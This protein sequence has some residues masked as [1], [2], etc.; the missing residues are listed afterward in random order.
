MR[1]CASEPDVEEAP[2]LVDVAAP[3]R[4]LAVLQPRHEDGIPLEPLCP[5]QRQQ[6]DARR[7]AR[8]ETALELGRQ[9]GHVVQVPCDLD[10]A[11][12]IA[13]PG[14][15]TLTQIV[16]RQG[17]PTERLREAAHR[18]GSGAVRATQAPQQRAGA[19]P[20]QQRPALKWDSGAVQQLFDAGRARVRAN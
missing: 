10:D 6:V 7:N 4:Q 20:S 1:P 9:L 3:D 12:E 2:L 11:R 18:L 15:L 13:L 16:W 8:P 14:L 5:M 17:L 19:F